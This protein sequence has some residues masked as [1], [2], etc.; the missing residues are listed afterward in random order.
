MRVHKKSRAIRSYRAKRDLA[1][2]ELRI[3]EAIVLESGTGR[4]ERS[5]SRGAAKGRARERE[6]ERASSETPW[7]HKRRSHS[8]E[9]KTQKFTQSQS[10]MGFVYF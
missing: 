10:T 8:Q 7:E 9:K 2:Q 6:R 4:S 1:D 5:H 3:A